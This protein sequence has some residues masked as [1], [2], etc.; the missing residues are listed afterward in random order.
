MNKLLI[1]ILM[2]T[3]S[4]FAQQKPDGTSILNRIDENLSSK[5][6]VFTSK[7]IIHGRRGSRTI[8]SK[9]WSEGDKQSFTEYLAPAREKGTKMLKLEDQLWVYNPSTDRTIQISGHML[10]QSVMG[11]DLSY[12]DMMEDSKLTDYYTAT[13][14]GSDTLQG[15]NC[16]VIELIANTSDIAYYKRM[17]WVDKERFF[18]LKEELFAKSGKLLKR[19][20]MFDVEQIDKRWFPKRMV[21]KDMLNNG[22]GTEFIIDSIEFDVDMPAHI[23]T[24]AALKE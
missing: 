11:S 4:V 7:M 8:E 2:M 17:L 13:V 16:W 18:P 15:R 20:E 3:S 22:E 23:F 9:S 6:R 5:N 10:R 14:T 24:K 21:F 19:M 1:A 12:E